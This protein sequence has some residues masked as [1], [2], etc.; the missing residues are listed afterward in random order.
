MKKLLVLALL[1]VATLTSV[2]A[3][4]A[5]TDEQKQVLK[6][7]LAKYDANHDGKLDKDEKSKFT[8]D[9]K[10]TWDKAFP[11]KAK[12]KKTD[13]GTAAPAAPPPAPIRSRTNHNSSEG[14]PHPH[15]A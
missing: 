7:F 1:C 6:D 2:Q 10:T 11:K 9:D 12:K 15:G 8:P 5:T 14:A 13:D 3:Q 4:K